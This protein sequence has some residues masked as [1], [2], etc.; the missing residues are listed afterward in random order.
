MISK[1]RINPGS[2]TVGSV[3]QGP[4]L[5]WSFLFL[6]T[7]EKRKIYDRY[8]KEGLTGGKYFF[9]KDIMLLRREDGWTPSKLFS[10]AMF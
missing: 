4:A 5:M 9:N 3:F 10:G 1:E 2:V 7:E 8:G 6:I